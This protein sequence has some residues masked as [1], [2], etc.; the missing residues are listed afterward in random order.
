[1]GQFNSKLKNVK[2][3]EVAW[4]GKKIIE[5]SLNELK[6]LTKKIKSP[7][8]DILEE[9][10]EIKQDQGQY[11]LIKH[12]KKTDITDVEIRK[13]ANILFT[14]CKYLHLNET[15]QGDT[16]KNKWYDAILQERTDDVK[17][18]GHFTDVSTIGEKAFANNEL[19][20]ITIPD[21][22]TTIGKKAFFY[23]HLKQV[24]IP[25]SVETIGEEAFVTY[26]LESVKIPDRVTTIGVGAFRNNKLKSVTLGKSVTT[27]EAKAFHF[28][29]LESVKIPDSVKTIGKD[30]F[31]FNK[32]TSVRLPDSV[33]TIEKK[34]FANNKLT[35][36]TLP[37]S[38]E[39]IGKKAFNNNKLI[40]V[41]IP[42]RVTTIGVGAF[43]NNMLE[44]VTIPDSV[45]TMGDE[46]F[47]ENKLTS[48]RIPVKFINDKDSFFDLDVKVREIREKRKPWGKE[49]Y[50]P[51][52]FELLLEPDPPLCYKDPNTDEEDYDCNFI[53]NNKENP[54]YIN[55]NDKILYCFKDIQR[56]LQDGKTTDPITR[57]P[58][59]SIHIMTQK[60]IEVAQK[61]AEGTSN[62]KQTG[63]QLKF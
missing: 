30:A 59:E 6:S 55:D 2:P 22:V 20:S 63:L 37:D 27:I 3:C 51:E 45:E 50:T 40:T 13:Q 23:T 34:A 24:T 39:T 41:T 32:L 18:F 42:D 47:Y 33:K 35:S 9:V 10:K 61:R 54:V 14:K 53:G 19:E 17:A 43:R 21:S 31:D 49:R 38:V 26:S 52:E 28:N 12:F 16:M 36:V 8:F 15:Y 56:W 29:R 62:K 44:S 25:N 4:D 5:F 11:T 48:V 58:I 60:E 1:M 7:E 46:A 57:K